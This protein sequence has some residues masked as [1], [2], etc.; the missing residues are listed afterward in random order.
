MRSLL[1]GE[2]FVL[3]DASDYA[4]LLRHE[5]ASISS[6]RFP[7]FLLPDSI[8]VFSLLID[9]STILLKNN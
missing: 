9:T 6:T 5:L 8:S 3:G 2:L 4:A 7:S 1:G